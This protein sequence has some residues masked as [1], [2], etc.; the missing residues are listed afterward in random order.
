[1]LADLP[2][3]G[4]KLEIVVT[5]RRFRCANDECHRYIFAERL[6][7]EAAAPRSR[8]TSRLD[9][10]V[11][12]LG[13]ML[14]GRPAERTARRLL[15]PVS[16][17][18]LLRTVRRRTRETPKQPRV[19]GIDDW[20]WRKGHRY[21]TLICDLEK[22]EIIDLL[23]DREP[24]TVAA[25][26]ASRPS[27]EVIARDRSGGYGFAAAQGR[28][29]AVQVADRWH[30]TE[31]ASAAFILAIRRRMRDVRGAFGQGIVDPA[32]LTAAERLQYEGWER[33]IAEEATIR[34]LYAKSIAIKEIVRR[35]GRSRKLVRD[36]CRGGQAEP[37]RPR[38]N[39]LDRWLDRLNAEWNSGCRNGA[40]LWRRCWM[41]L[42]SD[43]VRLEN[44]TEN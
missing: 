3:H 32:T 25:W 11:H 28:P 8:R 7:P 36:I 33:R 21:G 10:I 35:T 4:Q 38:A 13:M 29:E 27:I 42:K 2:S 1:M 5:T 44:V 15:I 30:L 39:S 17:D 26:L 23:P 34:A 24:A 9:A 40:E 6:N 16:K 19:I 41:S 18:T 43:P 14:G 20:A 37:F 22:R 12:H 31:N